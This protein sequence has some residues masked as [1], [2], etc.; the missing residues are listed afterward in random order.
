[1]ID[2]PGMISYKGFTALVTKDEE[3]KIYFGWVQLP[4]D[5]VAFQAETVGEVYKEFHKSVD[6]YL[7]W[8][9][10]VENQC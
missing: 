5:V 10:K 7:D 2:I 6:A 3:A 1:M 9:M 8:I 4:L